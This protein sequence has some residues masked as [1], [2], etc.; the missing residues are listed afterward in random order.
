MDPMS[1]IVETLLRESRLGGSVRRYYNDAKRFEIPLRG[2]FRAFSTNPSAATSHTA[3][4]ALSYYYRTRC[5]SD[6]QPVISSALF[7]EIQRRGWCAK[8]PDGLFTVGGGEAA[9]VCSVV[10]GFLERIPRRQD[11]RPYTP[12]VLLTKFLHFAFPATFAICDAQAAMSIQ[13]WSYLHFAERGP[14]W[15]LFSF[16]SLINVLGTGYRG[17]I[18]F[19]RL[20]WQMAS[21]EQRGELRRRAEEINESLGLANVS[22]GSVTPVDLLDKLLWEANGD[23]MKLG[24]YRARSWRST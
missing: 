9:G 3:L 10:E 22:G 24:L 11:A 4:S 23:P 7:D 12:Y 6:Y 16:G 14:E 1:C 2:K 13:M 20:F 8:P 5:P 15:R 21:I 18:S 17:V 19:Y